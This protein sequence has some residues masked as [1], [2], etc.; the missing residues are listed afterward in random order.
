MSKTSKSNCRILRTL[1]HVLNV[2][3]ELN[4]FLQRY[5]LCFNDN[6]P[7]SVYSQR[8]WVAEVPWGLDNQ[9]SHYSQEFDRQRWNLNVS[10]R[11]SRRNYV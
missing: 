9:S 10:A 6:A 5:A 11:K 7:I 3:S 4:T 8:V 1:D 2:N